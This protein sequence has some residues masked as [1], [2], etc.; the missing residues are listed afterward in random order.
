MF[1]ITS[2]PE[3]SHVLFQKALSPEISTLSLDSATSLSKS[4]AVTSTFSFSVKR[5]AV[6][7]TTAN[8]C[9]NISNS[10]SSRTTSDSFSNTSIS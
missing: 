4:L 5:F 2:V 8:A 6:S 10:T 1:Q 9:G 3:A 7:L